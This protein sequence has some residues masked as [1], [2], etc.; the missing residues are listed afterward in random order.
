MKPTKEQIDKAELAICKLVRLQYPE[1]V[2]AP[3]WLPGQGWSE[4][5]SY[6]HGTADGFILSL[7]GLLDQAFPKARNLK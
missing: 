3:D 6:N 1:E 2:S 7:R 5:G 4:P